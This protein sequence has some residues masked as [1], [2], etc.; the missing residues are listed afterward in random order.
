MCLRPTGESLKRTR[1]ADDSDAHHVDNSFFWVAYHASMV[2]RGSACAV[3]AGRTFGELVSA[4]ANSA[5]NDELDKFL[6]SYHARFGM[7][8]PI[9]LRSSACPVGGS[10]SNPCPYSHLGYR[11]MTTIHAVCMLLRALVTEEAVSEFVLALLLEHPADAMMRRFAAVVNTCWLGEFK[12]TVL[13]WLQAEFLHVHTRGRAAADASTSGGRRTF[14]ETVLALA[15]DG[16]VHRVARPRVARLAHEH[17]EHEWRVFLQKHDALQLKLPFQ[18]RTA[19]AL[20]Y[21]PAHRSRATVLQTRGDTPL[22][23]VVSAAGTGVY[24]HHHIAHALFS[25]RLVRCCPLAIVC[26]AAGEQYTEV[27]PRPNSGVEMEPGSLLVV[28]D[29]F[30][31]QPALVRSTVLV[32]RRGRSRHDVR[33][34]L[35]MRVHDILHLVEDLGCCTQYEVRLGGAVLDKNATIGGCGITKDSVL[36]VSATS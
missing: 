11:R 9:V 8:S 31:L 24:T 23:L 29:G 22:D 19:A 15:E 4:C 28:E 7:R 18:R 20:A 34:D 12:E 36:V 1:S 2:R 16:P 17:V 27:A 10:Q 3:A 26:V 32:V 35:R 13:R 5:V 30:C 21:S 33:V 14:A 25:A 6:V